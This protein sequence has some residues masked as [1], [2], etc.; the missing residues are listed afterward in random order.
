MPKGDEEEIA[1]RGEGFFRFVA[2]L[3]PRTVLE[4]PT[5]IPSLNRDH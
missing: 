1:D 5:L 4:R 3:A 2:L